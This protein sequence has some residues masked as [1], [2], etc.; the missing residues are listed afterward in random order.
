MTIE[1][2][3]APARPPAAPDTLSYSTKN[4]LSNHQ[5]ETSLYYLDPHRQR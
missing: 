3:L 5:I 1:M 2:T 4:I